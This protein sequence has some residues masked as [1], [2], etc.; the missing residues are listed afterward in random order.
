MRRINAQFRTPWRP[1][2]LQ[3]AALAVAAALAAGAVGGATWER[4]RLL[5]LKAQVVQLAEAERSGALPFAPRP[6]PGYDASARQFLRE[7]SAGWAPMLRT[8]ES[9]AMIGVTPSSVEFNAADGVA[10]V[11]LNYADSSALLDYLAR[12]NEGV[13]PGDGLGRWTLVETRMNPATAPN[14]A[15]QASVATIRSVW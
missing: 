7:R 11:T 14:A 12:V 2:R 8:L 6:T 3:L 1:G 10:Q 5:A 13:S 4:L 15:P 9:G